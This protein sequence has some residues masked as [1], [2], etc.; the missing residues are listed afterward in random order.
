M[1]LMW[2]CASNAQSFSWWGSN[3]WF[4][5]SDY[6]G[7]VGARY[8]FTKLTS[9]TVDLPGALGITD[10]DLT[11]NVFGL[12]KNPD[13]FNE[14]WAILYIDRLG[15]RFSIDTQNFYGRPTPRPVPSLPPSGRWELKVD[16]SRIGID[17]DLVRFPFLRLGLN[18][19]YTFSDAKFLREEG[20]RTVY[21]S[22][23]PM[24][25]GLHGVVMPGRIRDIPVI[26]QAR[27][28][29]P[30]P[31]VK[32]K[33]ESRVTDWEISGGLRPSIWETSV[34]SA[35]TFAV[36]LEAGYRAVDFDMK[37]ERSE[38]ALTG[39]ENSP[40]VELKAHWE[41]PFVQIEIVY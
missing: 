21:Q 23:G 7:A 36:G 4:D 6:R 14:L 22:T 15:L 38:N 29:F 17:L 20:S 34:L 30:V 2:P 13:A 3:Q 32:R 26:G 19:D 25:I 1:A 31:G 41:G 10:K 18:Y 24:T 8:Y 16:N 5:W 12:P 35:T 40:Q 11:G 28:R 33:C 27:L 9:G 37:G 39:F